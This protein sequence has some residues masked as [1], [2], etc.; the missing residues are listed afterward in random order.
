MK[1][2]WLLATMLLLA[3]TGCQRKEMVSVGDAWIR[4]GAVP[5]SPGVAYFT[6]HGGP[7]DMVLLSVT[8][9]NVIRTEMHESM[10][11]SGMATMAPMATVALPARATMAFAPGGKHVMLFDVNPAIKR[12]GVQTLRFTFADGLILM[13]DARVVAAGD[14]APK[15]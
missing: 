15:F 9:P 8:S 6:L 5:R 13:R 12:G 2:V 7:R 14:P 11:R 1:A 10:T 3:A 4:L